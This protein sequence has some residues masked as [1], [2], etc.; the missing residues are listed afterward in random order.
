MAEAMPAA[1]GVGLSLH[2]RRESGE[3]SKFDDIKAL[4]EAAIQVEFI[5]PDDS[6]ITQ[7]VLR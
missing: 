7:E 2:L 3:E 6:T 4:Q 5:L 1:S